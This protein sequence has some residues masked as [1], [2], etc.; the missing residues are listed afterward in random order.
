MILSLMASWSG[1]YL[2]WRRCCQLWVSSKSPISADGGSG[3]EGEGEGEVVEGVRFQYL[4]AVKM[5][6]ETG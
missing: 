4:F 5:K 3:G 6:T 1:R 2:L